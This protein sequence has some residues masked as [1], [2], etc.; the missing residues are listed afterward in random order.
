MASTQDKDE[1]HDTGGDIEVRRKR[2][3]IERLIEAA[4]RPLA[5]AP[6]D[7]ATWATAVTAVTSVLEGLW[8]KGEIAGATPAEAFTVVC[9]LGST[10]TA[11]DFLEGCMIVQITLTML[12]PAEFIELTIKQHMQGR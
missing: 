6:N 11:Q 12:R 5:S 1:T 3:E 8:A 10:M 9:G 2:A 4:L 7:E